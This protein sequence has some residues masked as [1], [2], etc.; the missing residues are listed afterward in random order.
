MSR[1]VEIKAR[2]DSIDD[3]LQRVATL[4]TKSQQLTQSDTFFFCDA[5]RL[6]LRQIEESNSAELIFY[7]RAD[8]T[9]AS[10]STYIR[11]PIPN[12]DDMVNILRQTSGVRGVVR[13][14]RQLYLFEQTRIHVD[15]VEN[16]GDFVELEV[17]LRS[18]Q[19][20]EDG[21]K[22]A[23]KLMTHLNIEESDLESVAYIDLLELDK[24]KD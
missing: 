4:T 3:L 6:K 5:G 19:S 7:R 14:V 10:L 2:V 8:T 23:R 15:R 21:E 16:L 17:V 18:E 13:K 11:T 24:T 1:N 9:T 22:I 12:A 20:Q